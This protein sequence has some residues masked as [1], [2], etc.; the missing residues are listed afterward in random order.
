V[1]GVDEKKLLMVGDTFIALQDLGHAARA[2]SGAKIIGV[3]G[4]VGKTGTKEMLA[5]A[6]GVLGQ[7][8]ASKASHNNHWG[9]PF[10]LSAMDAGC[11]YAIFEMGMNHSGEITPL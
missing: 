5:A 2:R 10:S 4:S 11:D 7:T 8:H 1:P 9:V 3:T 6:F